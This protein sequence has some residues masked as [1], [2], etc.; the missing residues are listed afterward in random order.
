MTHCFG[1][2]GVSE[3]CAHLCAFLCMNQL[4]FRTRHYQIR[5]WILGQGCLHALPELNEQVTDFLHSTGAGN[6]LGVEDFFF[7]RA[8]K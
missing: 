1:P 6:F 8:D 5:F 7:N 3:K 2:L 4:H